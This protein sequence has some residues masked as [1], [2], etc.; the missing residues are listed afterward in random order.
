MTNLHCPS[1]GAEMSL[2]VVLAHEGLRKCYAEMIKLTAPLPEQL[3]RYINLFRPLKVKMRPERFAKLANEIISG[4]QSE[5]ICYNGREWHVPLELWRSAFE[6]VQGRVEAGKMTRPLGN[7]NYLY[8]ILADISNK[9]EAA[10]EE[11]REQARRHPTSERRAGV[12]KDAVDM[13]DAIGAALDPEL[14]KIINHKADPM[15]EDVKKK[16]EELKKGT[17]HE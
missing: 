16:L 15:P 9:A 2:D 14:L 17:H 10:I 3:L 12:K 8:A 4:I 11:E 5:T 6:A 7:H 13:A 1:C